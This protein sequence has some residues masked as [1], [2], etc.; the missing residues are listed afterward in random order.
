MHFTAKQKFDIPEETNVYL[1]D[2]T[3]TEV[4]EDVFIDVL[5]EK[6]DI[7]W[8]LTDASSVEGNSSTIIYPIL[9][10]TTKTVEVHRHSFCVIKFCFSFLF[11]C[12]NNV[13]DKIILSL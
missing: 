11:S 1:V 4:D 9:F 5:E 6:S 12:F 3:G 7:V 8:T 10:N 2:E 13:T